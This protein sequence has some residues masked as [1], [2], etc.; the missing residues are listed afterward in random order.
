[1][2]WQM[3]GAG[4]MV[5]LPL[6]PATRWATDLGTASA[7]AWDVAMVCPL[8]DS[9]FPDYLRQVIGGTRPPGRPIW[10]TAFDVE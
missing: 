7:G 2:V 3:Y 9:R 8:N 4:V 10:S 1:M 6:H 5:S